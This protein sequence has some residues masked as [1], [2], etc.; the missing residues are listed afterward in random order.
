VFAKELTM[1]NILVLMTTA[2]RH[3]AEKIAQS[4]L[5][6]HLIACANILGP[7]SSHYWWQGKIERAKEF[8]VL[9]K[10]DDKLFDQLAKSIKKT[11]SY[12]TPEILALPISSGWPPYL[13][14]LNATLQTS[15]R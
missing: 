1:A 15:E 11:H 13:K 8:L 10:S 12:E 4:L 6:R 3:E 7:V 9:M 5:E 14:W 2:T